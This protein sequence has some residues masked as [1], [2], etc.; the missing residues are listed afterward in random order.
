MTNAVYIFSVLITSLLVSLLFGTRIIN[1]IKKLQ[2]LGQEIKDI[3][4]DNHKK[5]AGTPNM[6]G[7]IIFIGAFFINYI[8]IAPF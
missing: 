7:L 2:P 1:F 5:K 3:M 4:P 6:G 8:W